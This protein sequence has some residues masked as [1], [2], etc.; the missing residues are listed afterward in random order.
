MAKCFA[1]TLIFV[2]FAVVFAQEITVPVGDQEV[3]IT[4]NEQEITTEVKPQD[5]D[6]V[7]EEV[8]IN[9]DEAMEIARQNGQLQEIIVNAGGIQKPVY[10]YCYAIGG[11]NGITGK[12]TIAYGAGTRVTGNQAIYFLDLDFRARRNQKLK[13]GQ[14]PDEGLAQGSSIG[15]YVWSGTAVTKSYT[16]KWT[17]E[18]YSRV[19]RAMS[20]HTFYIPFQSGYPLEIHFRNAAC[21][22]G[23][24]GNC[25][26]D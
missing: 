25:V 11:Y 23:L 1:V 9:P 19:V 4:V 21:A 17:R 13:L 20:S 5:E 14:N 3:K 24:W 12:D 8:F 16:T 10:I 18:F 22:Q 7:S 2:L 15:D 26:R 6:A